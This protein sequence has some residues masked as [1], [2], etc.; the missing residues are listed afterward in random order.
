MGNQSKG[1][2][3]LGCVKR[4]LQNRQGI[5]IGLDNNRHNTWVET[6][7]QNVEISQPSVN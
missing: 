2:K 4:R 1:F 5:L 6:R 7:H 3:S